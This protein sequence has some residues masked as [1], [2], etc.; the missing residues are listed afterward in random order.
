MFFDVLS[1]IRAKR[2]ELKDA[3]DALKQLREREPS[4]TVLDLRT[5]SRKVGGQLSSYEITELLHE[6]RG[7]GIA[8]LVYRVK[9][10]NGNRTSSRFKSLSEKPSYDT[11]RDGNSFEV[12]LANVEQTYELAQ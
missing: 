4:L 3:V 2:P 12:S 5:L 8:T 7:H 9:D 10:R 11:D 6:L 1:R